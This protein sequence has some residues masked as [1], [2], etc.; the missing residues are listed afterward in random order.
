MT[1][2]DDLHPYD[3]IVRRFHHDD[4]DELLRARGLALVAR[5]LRLPSLP[6]LGLRYDMYF[7][8]GGIGI[9]DQIHISLPC[10]PTETNAIIARLGFATPEEA[11][12]DEAWRDDFEFLVLDGNDTEPLHTAVAA[13]VEEHRAEFQPPPDEPMRTWFSRESGPNAW[14]L[15]YEREGVL[16]FLAL[17]QA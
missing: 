6:P 13:F 17:E 7:Y 5:L 15:V 9:S 2:T 16:S 1:D 12:A 11:V 3:D 10:T 8:S 4:T 14:S